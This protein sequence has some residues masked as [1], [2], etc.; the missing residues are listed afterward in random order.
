MLK[1]RTKARDDAGKIGR[2][3]ELEVVAR[4]PVINVPER[5]FRTLKP[6]ERLSRL[7]HPHRG[8]IS[9][10]RQRRPERVNPG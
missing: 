8:H 4:R 10:T 3:E 7:I 6:P 5:N 9:L 1:S 2:E